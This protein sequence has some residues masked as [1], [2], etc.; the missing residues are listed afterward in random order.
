MTSDIQAEHFQL[1][2]EQSADAEP[3]LKAVRANFRDSFSV[4]GKRFVKISRRAKSLRLCL[5]IQDELLPL[6]SS[7]TYLPK[8][9][10]Y[11]RDSHRSK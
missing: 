3:S 10:G 8:Q 4:R 9:I 5:F 6:T 7:P 2:S 11:Q 1:F